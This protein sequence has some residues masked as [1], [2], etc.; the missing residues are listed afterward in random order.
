[1]EKKCD[2][3]LFSIITIVLNGEQFLERCVKS[4][5]SQDYEQKEHIIIDGG[6]VDNTINIIEKYDKYISNW[7]SEEDNG[8]YDAYNKGVSLSK[9]DYIYFLNCDDY[10]AHPSVLSQIASVLRDNPVNLLHGNVNIEWKSGVRTN[11]VQINTD[12]ELFTKTICHEAVFASRHLFQKIGCFNTRFKICAD[13]EWLLRAFKKHNIKPLYA[14]IL[15][16]VR[17]PYHKSS[18]N[19]I[20]RRETFRMNL[21]YFSFKFL[22]YFPKQVTKKI[23]SLF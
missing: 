23:F 21:M 13:R 6:S 14:D 20:D 5:I 18:I 19:K 22:I 11:K 2:W 3:P 4:V 10:F 12:Y 8:I 15:I 17:D 1:M 16:S 7:I 9:G